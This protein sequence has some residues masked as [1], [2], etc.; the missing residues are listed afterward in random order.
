[1]TTSGSKLSGHVVVTG[2]S[3]F[4]GR[5]LIKALT[6]RGIDII[7][8]T[9][10]QPVDLDVVWHEI[11][12]YRDAPR[13]EDATL[14]HLAEESDIAAAA[15]RGKSH[16]DE[17]RARA[18]AL[19]EKGY[20]RLVYAS[21]G[22]V[23][24]AAPPNAYVEGKLAAERVVLAA[25]GVVL[26]LANIYGPNMPSRTVISDIVKQIPGQGPLRLRRALPR[27]DFLWVDDA[28][29]GFAAVALGTAAGVFDLG[30]GQ[31]IAMGELARLALDVAG[32]SERPLLVEETEGTVKDVIHLDTDRLRSEFGW[33]TRIDLRTGLACLLK[34]AA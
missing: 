13:A 9:R 4:V 5:A 31:S 29:E 12:D 18:K 6:R 33:Q 27:R 20:R 14:I 26:R 22:Q 10:R 21:S 25:G 15:M 23:Y 24:R 34:T 8:V 30:S 1:M 17:V 2:A 28:A 19:A 16:V 11:A 7:A 3:G 32:E